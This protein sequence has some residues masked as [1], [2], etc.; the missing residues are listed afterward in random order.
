MFEPNHV[1]SDHCNLLM[2]IRC[3]GHMRLMVYSYSKIGIIEEKPVPG[4]PPHRVVVR[5]LVP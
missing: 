4:T 3:C 5:Y 2:G 1:G